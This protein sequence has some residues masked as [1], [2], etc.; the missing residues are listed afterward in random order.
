MPTADEFE[1]ADP[2]P[3]EEDVRE[4]R[5]KGRALLAVALENPFTDQPLHRSRDLIAKRVTLGVY[6][7]IYVAGGDS[8]EDVWIRVRATPD[9][10][11]SGVV[12]DV[13]VNVI[14]EADP[15][16]ISLHP[17]APGRKP[18]TGE[19]IIRWQRA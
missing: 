3:T 2:D 13:L 14:Q 15:A 11:G 7:E 12:R 9:H 6:V 4:L 8:A 16:N 19:R 18:E 5:R 10:H 1:A 17:K